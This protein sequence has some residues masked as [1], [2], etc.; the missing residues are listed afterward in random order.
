MAAAARWAGRGEGLWR[1]RVAGCHRR[2]HVH[3]AEKRAGPCGGIAWCHPHAQLLHVGGGIPSAGR[4]R[5]ASSDPAG[6]RR[7][8]VVVP[9]LGLLPTASQGPHP[10]PGGQKLT[11][12]GSPTTAPPT[13]APPTTAPPTSAPPTTAPPTTA[14]PTTAPPTTA[15]PTTAPPTTAPPTTAPP[16]ARP[17]RPRPR[18]PR[19]RHRPRRHR[20]PRRPRR[21]RQ[22]ARRRRQRRRLLSYD[23]LGLPAGDRRAQCARRR[24][25]P[26]TA[27]MSIRTT[28]TAMA[29]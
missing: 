7:P 28:P 17:R 3:G 14:P 2:G 29:I 22:Q 12:P 15:P 8:G 11:A 18:R 26:Y 25:R 19:P 21:R 1:D 27:A 9:T 24:E 4:R 6:A 10:D 16:A 23:R 13:S 20:R 5:I